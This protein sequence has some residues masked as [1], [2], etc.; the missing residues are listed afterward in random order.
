MPYP[1]QRAAQAALSYAGRAACM[2][3]VAYYRANAQTLRRALKGTG[4]FCCGGENSPYVW[5]QCPGG[6]DSWQFFD[7]LLERARIVGTPGAGFGPGG[8]GYFR[9][10]GFGDK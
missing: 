3:A 9:L 5:M 4:V 6:M 10:T 1:V 2:Q 8:E 7:Y